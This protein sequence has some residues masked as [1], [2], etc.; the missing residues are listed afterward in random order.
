[1]IQQEKIQ[2]I[3]EDALVKAMQGRPY[4]E[5]GDLFYPD[6]FS[7]DLSKELYDYFKGFTF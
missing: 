2:K 1:M 5:V 3:I 4:I 7:R 6:N